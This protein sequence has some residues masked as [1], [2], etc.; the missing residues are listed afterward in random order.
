MARHRR[1]PPMPWATRLAMLVVVGA[2]AWGGGLFGFVASIPRAVPD[3]NTKTDGIVVLTGGSGRLS[4]G[5]TLLSEG[6]AKT[7][8]VSGVYRGI[9]V[10]QLLQLERRKPGEMECCIVLGRAVDTIGN[11]IETRTWAL[12]SKYASLRLVTAD[13]H[14]P[15]ALME[16]S[17]LL[18][19][20]TVVPHPVFPEHVKT[21]SW[22]R[23][24]GTAK[25][26]IGEYNKFLFAW[27]RHQMMTL[28]GSPLP[29]VD[30]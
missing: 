11:A 23:F 20:T 5:L 30:D 29:S 18:P 9:D 19:E 26:V 8:F 1:S 21:E 27:A 15:R 4:A 17:F 28:A 7:L 10:N 22:W 24:P 12:Q 16:V 25:L 3:A 2:L 14:M 6:M 13:Y